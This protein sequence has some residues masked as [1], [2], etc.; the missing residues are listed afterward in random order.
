MFQLA[1]AVENTCLGTGVGM[2]VGMGSA[3]RSLWHYGPLGV[4]VKIGA[5]VIVGIFGHSSICR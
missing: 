2:G 4:G 5:I 3:L 1:E